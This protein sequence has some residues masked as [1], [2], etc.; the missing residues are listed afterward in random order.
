MAK[1]KFCNQSEE[2]RHSIATE[3]CEKLNAVNT[4]E[5]GFAEL[6]EKLSTIMDMKCFAYMIGMCWSQDWTKFRGMSKLGQFCFVS[7]IEGG[8][9]RGKRI[10]SKIFIR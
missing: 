9:I 6:K 2:R 8:I 4:P 3:L 10:D 5:D 1:H 7:R